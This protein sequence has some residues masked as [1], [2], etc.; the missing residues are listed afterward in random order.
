M[1]LG[2]FAQRRP[3]YKLRRHS[4]RCPNGRCPMTTLNEGRSISS[5]DTTSAAAAIAGR[6]TSLNEGR[7]ISS[8]DTRSPTGA[9]GACWSAL[10]EGRSISSGDTC[11]SSLSVS[12]RYTLNE[13]RSI[14][15]GDT[16][17][18]SGVDACVPMIAQ[19]RPEYKLRRHHQAASS[20]A[21]AAARVAQRRPEYK[22]RRHSTCWPPFTPSTKT[23]QRRPEYKL[24][25]HRRR[26]VSLR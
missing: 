22:L 2:R 1:S 17:W 26:V 21:V 4:G 11:A 14:S 20:V 3:E 10:N 16:G 7:S 24:R 13:G 23:A 8:G 12:W 19:R 15:S 5:G 6:S 18:R 25:R 9:C